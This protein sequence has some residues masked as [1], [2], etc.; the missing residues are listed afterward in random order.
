MLFKQL[1]EEPLDTC[2]KHLL[3]EVLAMANTS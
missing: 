2:G 1:L 3:R